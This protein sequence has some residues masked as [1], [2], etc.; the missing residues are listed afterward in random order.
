MQYIIYF[1]LYIYIVYSLHIIRSKVRNFYLADLIR[2]V[3]FFS[4]F[5]LPIYYYGLPSFDINTHNNYMYL[6]AII[7]SFVFLIYQLP[8]YKIFFN[9]EMLL[10]FMPKV[11]FSD[12]LRN[13]YSLIGSVFMEELFFRSMIPES[14]IIIECITS[15][16]LFSIAHYF[17]PK[18]RKEYTFKSYVYLFVLSVF[19]YISYKLSGSIMPAILAHALYNSPRFIIVSYQYLLQKKEYKNELS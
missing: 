5:I 12:V 1:L 8:S 17:I 13:S 10:F 6:L 9:K 19:W 3:I 15:G 7:P 18:I 2:T 11:T 14:N 4:P 16:I